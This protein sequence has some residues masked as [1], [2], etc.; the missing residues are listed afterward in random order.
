MSLITWIVLGLITGFISSKLI[1]KT[2]EGVF[3]NIGLGILGAVVGGEIFSKLGMTGVTGLNL[4][5]MLVSVGG[6]VLLL[7]VYHALKG[8]SSRRAV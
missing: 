2:D 8:T 4:W 5:S 1:E 6:A 7:V 3:M